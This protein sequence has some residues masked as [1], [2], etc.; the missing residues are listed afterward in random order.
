MKII[1]ADQEKAVIFH[2]QNGLS[3][4]ETAKKVKIHYSTVH[5]VAKRNGIE[6]VRNK[7]GRPPEIHEVVTRNIIRKIVT[8]KCDTAT[9][10]AKMLQQDLDIHVSAQTIRNVLK[11]S[12]LKA[13]HKVKK[14]AISMKNQKKRLDFAKKH[15]NWTVNDWK[16][17]IWSDETKINRFGSD[18][19]LWCWKSKGEGLSD[20][21]VQPTVK[22]GGGSVMVWGCMTASGV[23][24]LSKIDGGLDAELY[25]KILEDELVRTMEY[26]RM[27]REDVIFQHDNDPKHTSKKAKKCLQDLGMTVLEWPPQSPDLNPI[28]HLWDVLKRKL[29]DYPNPP[30]GIHE[31]WER[32]EEQWNT[33]TKEE[34]MTLIES[35]PRRIEAVLKAKGRNTKY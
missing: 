30:K 28:E 15:Q 9:Q 24:H 35:M 20:R 12:G 27:K 26:Y 1:S 11:A 32:V 21:T 29:A 18:G 2:L 7:G 25:C 19:R 23:G 4:R 8:G 17:V 31:L 5:K 33:I 22:H 16:Q 34:C 14:P 6:R 10:A 3:Y 13:K